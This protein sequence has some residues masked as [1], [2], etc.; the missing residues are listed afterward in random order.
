MKKNGFTLVELL[1]V[2]AILAILMLLIVPNVLGMFNSGKKNAFKVQVESLAKAAEKKIV[3]DA[4]EGSNNTKY[5]KGI[6]IDCYDYMSL[7]ESDS[8]IKYKITFDSSNKVST[9]AVQNENYCYVNNSY[10]DG[11]NEEDFTENANLV[12][13]A[14]ECSCG[15][16]VYWINTSNFGK[17]SK[18]S[19]TYDSIEE[20]NLSD[21][22]RFIRTKISSDNRV[23]GHEVCIYLNGNSF[24]LAPNYYEIDDETSKNKLQKDMSNALGVSLSCG[25]GSYSDGTK[26]VGCHYNSHFCRARETG[27]VNCVLSNGKN[28]IVTEEGKAWCQE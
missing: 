17:S 8:D 6:G 1:A 13:S 16:Y 18:P 21:A 11:I 25:S 19:T 22:G 5:C 2:I 12:C 27:L 15:K 10:A 3:A 20:L 28:C 7:S 14:T 9:V 26:Y 24:C 23:L 4:L